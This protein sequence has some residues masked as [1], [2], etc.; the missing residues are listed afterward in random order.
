MCLYLHTNNQ[1]KERKIAEKDIICYK[2]LS[3]NLFPHG[4]TWYVN[5]KTPKGKKYG[6]LA[7]S[8]FKC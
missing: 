3:A 5:D 2:T 8:P 6:Q 7:P 1:K 4:E